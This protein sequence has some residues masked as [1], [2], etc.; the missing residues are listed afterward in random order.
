[1]SH[2]LTI[3]AFALA[4]ACASSSSSSK[5]GHDAA[6]APQEEPPA[7][8]AGHGG[9]P[10]SVATGGAA[11][12]S[13]AARDGASGSAGGGAGGSASVDAAASGGATDTRVAA[14]ADAAIA[15]AQD[16]GVIAGGSPVLTGAAAGPAAPL[17]GYRWE[18]PCKGMPGGDLCTWDGTNLMKRM[19]V[20]KTFGGDPATVYDLRVRIRGVVEGK[21]YRDGAGVDVKPPGAAPV[22]LVGGAPILE[23]GHDYNVY[24]IMVAEPKQT[25]YLNAIRAEGHLVWSLD[26]EATIKVKGGTTVTL[27][28]YDTN[29]IIIAN[30][31]ASARTP[32]GGSNGK[33]L[34]VPGVPPAPAPYNGQFI[35]LDV[36]SVTSPK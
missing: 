23:A 3:P 18:V 31:V 6:L 36:V 19:E 8:S 7:A 2:R 20:A 33:P 25:Y 17:A 22:F 32:T 29:M 16:A 28:S 27:A 21:T 4:C 10:S 11:G 9:A 26:Y 30:T 15:G 14:G 13:Q 5:T 35:Q 12:A 34:V 1:M 24:A